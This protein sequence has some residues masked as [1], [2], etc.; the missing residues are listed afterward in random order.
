MVGRTIG[1]TSNCAKPDD[2]SVAPVSL[3]K[4][5]PSKSHFH[6]GNGGLGNAGEFGKLTLAQLL[7]IAKN[8]DRFANRNLNPLLRGTKLFHIMASDSREE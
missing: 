3:H 6:G 5:Q 4:S 1:L 2:L 7:K 8:P